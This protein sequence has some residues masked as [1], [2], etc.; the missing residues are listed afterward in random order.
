MFD[1]VFDF[2][3]TLIG[4]YSIIEVRDQKK[5]IGVIL[6]MGG[7]E[8]RIDIV[9]YKITKKKGNRTAGYLYLN[10][11]SI[12][13]GKSSYTKTDIGALK[14]QKLT[15]TQKKII[16]ILKH[17][18]HKKNLPISSHL[19]ENLVLDAYQYNYGFVPRRFT[20]KVIMVLKHIANNLD[21]AVIRSIENTNN[22]I[23]NIPEANKTKI[24]DAC[25]ALIKDYEYQPN[26]IVNIMR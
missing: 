20:G 8:H 7:A 1:C 24:I 17:W 10:N 14:S 12:W 11:K 25:K 4:Y 5:S 16:V 13:A 15:E 9:P 21:I 19:L 26:S 18:K 22:I 6:N 2:L 23:T 3:K